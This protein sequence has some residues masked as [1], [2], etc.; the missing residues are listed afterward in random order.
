MLD[1]ART[2]ILIGAGQYTDRSNSENGHT[3]I[4]I[5]AEAIKNTIEDSQAPTLFK[6]IDV[7]ACSGLT[8]DAK[9][10]NTPVSGLVKNMPRAVAREAGIDAKHYYYA[11]AGGNTP[12]MFVNHF[13]KLIARGDCETVVL[14]GGEA[15]HTMNLRFNHWSKILRPKGLW[16]DK[17]GPAPIGI[18]EIRDGS[19]V[20]ENRYAMNL[21]ANVYPLFENALRAHYGHSVK[22]HELHMCEL[23]AKFSDVAKTNPYAWFKNPPSKTEILEHSVKN[24]MVGFPYRKRLNSMIMVNQSAAVAMTTVEKAKAMGIPSERWVYLH[25]YADGYDVWNVS[26]RTNYFSS[27]AI[28]ALTKS[29]LAMAGKSIDEIAAFDIYSCFPSAVQ[30]AC[31]A[32][33]IQHTDTRKLTL[34]GGLPYFGGPGNNYSMH[35][36]AEMH[37]WARENPQETG[38]MNANGWYLTKHAVGIY[39]QRRP[40]KPLPIAKAMHQQVNDSP[41]LNQDAKGP[42]TIETFTVLHNRKN[43]PEKAIIIARDDQG[44]RCLATTD[45]KASTLEQLMKEESVGRPG[46]LIK[47]R[48]KTLFEL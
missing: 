16:K 25:G 46:T 36:V 29:A 47:R 41:I 12:Q 3:P 18:G 5:I 37:K 31:D 1:D 11:E 14:A 44:H 6:H 48:N 33:G 8:V 42:A 21:P 24:R 10:V 43:Q 13:A 15:L 7:L 4:Q 22:Q 45:N 35:A 28:K 39:S 27:P 20:Y 19:S 2:P 32:M 30:I 34:T 26:Q 38:L 23:F 9:Q 17:S 40:N